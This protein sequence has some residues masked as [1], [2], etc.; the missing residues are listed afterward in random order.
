MDMFKRLG[1]LGHDALMSC[2]LAR[3]QLLAACRFIRSQR[4][5]NWPAGPLL[6]AAAK[7]ERPTFAAV[8][9][10]FRQ[11]NEVCPRPPAHGLLPTA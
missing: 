8:Y 2:L 9:N 11:R 5:W 3:G 1:P 6:A 10:F 7:A 4:L